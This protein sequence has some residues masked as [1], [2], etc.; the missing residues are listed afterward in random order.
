MIQSGHEF[1]FH[2]FRQ[3]VGIH[4]A[5]GR[6]TSRAAPRNP[7]SRKRVNTSPH[8]PSRGF[9]VFGP[10]APIQ[11][12]VHAKETRHLARRKAVRATGCPRDESAGAHPGRR[13]EAPSNDID[14][15]RIGLHRHPQHRWVCKEPTHFVSQKRR[16]HQ[17]TEGF[18][19]HQIH[20]IQLDPRTPKTTW[21]RSSRWLPIIAN[22]RV[23]TS[24]GRTCHPHIDAHVHL[25]CAP[26]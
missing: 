18:V 2:R 15:S 6:S 5:C 3:D 1:G 22:K 4:L 25:V 9:F 16:G 19:G 17:A 21:Q 8:C 26:G 13:G 14:R 10:L 23:A 20:Q 24:A 11:H 7:P 12:H